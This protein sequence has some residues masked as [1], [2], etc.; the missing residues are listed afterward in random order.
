MKELTEFNNMKKITN[1]E[2][3]NKSCKK[4]HPT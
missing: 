3:N 1:L 4:E 2:K